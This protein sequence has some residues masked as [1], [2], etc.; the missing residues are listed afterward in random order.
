MNEATVIT[1]ERGGRTYQRDW[2]NGKF[3]CDGEEIPESEYNRAIGIGSAPR[4]ARPHRAGGAFFSHGG[5]TLTERQ[6]EFLR[7]MCGCVLW[8]GTSAWTDLL[9]D[10]L[11]GQFA[12]RPMTVG[13]MVSTLREK[14]L[15]TVGVSARDNG[16]GREVR[17]KLMTVTDL[18]REVLCA[19]GLE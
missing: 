13:A 15:F 18:G 9:A 3:Y 10:Q 2:Y 5:C 14:G 11:G 19:L 6:C 7:E 8:D 4:A 1:A 16:R 17:R 12:G